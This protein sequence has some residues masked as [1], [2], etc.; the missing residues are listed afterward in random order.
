MFCSLL[1]SALSNRLKIPCSQGRVGSSPTPSIVYC[2]Y[3][4]ANAFFSWYCF[5][6][7]VTH[8][9]RTRHEYARIIRADAS[10]LDQLAELCVL[11]GEAYLQLRKKCVTPPHFDVIQAILPVVNTIDTRDYQTLVAIN[12]S[13]FYSIH[14]YAGL[15]WAQYVNLN[16]KTE[17]RHTTPKCG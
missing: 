12:F 13:F 2:Q 6:S 4:K 1:Q 15:R 10:R 7:I 11:F 14:L 17:Q 9:L 3:V 5:D 8:F 16:D